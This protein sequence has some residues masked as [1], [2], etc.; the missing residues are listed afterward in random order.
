MPHRIL[1]VSAADRIAGA[2]NSLLQLL[3]GL[4]RD[5][6]EPLVALPGPGPLQ[7]ALA[8]LDV[9]A[10]HVPLFRPR[11][12]Y[13][14]LRV[15]S[16]ASR[17]ATAAGRLVDVVAAE[18]VD[19]IHAQNTAAMV[20][21][22]RAAR[23]VDVPCLWH[24]R[25]LGGWPGLVRLV[26][27][28][29]SAA[30]AVSHAV[31]DRWLPYLQ[32]LDVRVVHNGIDAD[33]FAARAQPGRF[34][35]ELGIA[36]DAPLL[37]I[38]GQLVP[39]K[40]HGDFLYAVARVRDEF[41]AA[42]A[43]IAGADLFGDHPRYVRGL[44]RLASKLGLGQAVRFLGYRD[45]MPDLMADADVLVVASDAEPFGRVALEAMAVGTPVVGYASGG[46]PE[47]VEDGRSGLLA[48]PGS[49]AALAARV[50]DLLRDPVRAR[51]MGEAGRRR[52]RDL[53]SA[54]AHAEDVA[55]VYRQ[56][57]DPPAQ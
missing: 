16:M 45:D 50:D 42:S 49:P 43:V 9:P 56:V 32:G 24:L 15:L 48:E 7:D 10:I 23:R 34:R 17:M 14:P 35:A 44:H 31:A 2:E 54:G 26:A 38:A 12:T 6:F 29:A 20:P 5:E 36:S 53:F 27:P 11:R 57:L 41:P 1:Y 4:D 21:V 37:A 3:A 46:L 28:S 55:A 30:V 33:A 52:V 13:N 25:D 40:G 47:V 19:L 22:S 51:A 39:W 8:E 18:G